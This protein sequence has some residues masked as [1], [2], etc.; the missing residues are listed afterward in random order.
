L[1]TASGLYVGATARREPRWLYRVGTSGAATVL[2]AR[3]FGDPRH[4][5]FLKRSSDSAFAKRDTYLYSPPCTFLAAAG[6]AAPG[7]SSWSLA[8]ATA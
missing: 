3:A 4:I 8:M 7:A 1:A 6:A 5:G 2:A